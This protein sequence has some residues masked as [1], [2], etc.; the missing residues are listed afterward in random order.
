MRMTLGIL[1]MKKNRIYETVVSTYDK[2]QRPAAAAM[3]IMLIN[4]ETFFIRPFKTTSTY[5]NLNET[6]CGVVN[7]SSSPQIFYRTTFKH[8]EPRLRIPSKWY[9]PAKTVLAPRIKLAEAHVEFTVRS[10]EVE[11]EDRT[12]LTCK[13]KFMEGRRIFPQAYCRSN[14]ALIECI[15]HATR[16]KYHLSHGRVAE[17]QKL[18]NLIRYYR[19]LAIRVSPSSKDVQMIEEILS[20]VGRWRKEDGGLR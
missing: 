18:I 20:H 12:R 2:K 3:G 7:I 19:N 11:N 14:Y 1:G 10:L 9:A 5:A 15:I 17:A 13:A 6:K 8:E 4:E 16:V